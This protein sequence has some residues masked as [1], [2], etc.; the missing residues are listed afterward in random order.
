ML[1][2]S[3]ADSVHSLSA[4]RVTSAACPGLFFSRRQGLDESGPAAAGIDPL[5]ELIH[6]NR[7]AKKQMALSRHTS[8]ASPDRAECGAI[9]STGS[10][11]RPQPS[12]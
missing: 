6:Q 11:G 1:Q 12:H 9:R 2:A 3:V 7:L 8:A 5:I 4:V 10:S